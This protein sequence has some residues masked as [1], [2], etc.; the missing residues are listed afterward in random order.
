MILLKKILLCVGGFLAVAGFLARAADE[1]LKPVEWTVNDEKRQ[2][3]VILPMRKSD[4]PAP[5][6]FVFHGHG[7]T[8]QSMERKG[9]QKWWPEAIIVCPQGLPT[10]T[11]RDPEGKRSGWQPGL[12][13]NNDRD[14]KFFDAVLKTLRDKYKVDDKRIYATGHSNGGGFTYLLAAERGNILAAVAPSAAGS[15]TLAKRKDLSPLPVLHIAGEKDEIV[16]FANQQRT[17]EGVRKL[18][19]C[20]TDGK[21]WAT[22][23]KLVGT[24]YPS[25]EGPPFVS[26]IHPGTHAYPPEAPELTVKFFKEH[27]RK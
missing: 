1:P 27:S 23:G 22:S 10:A 16:P 20:E 12:G 11:I 15:G 24:I 26:V 18:N 8:M 14:L 25:K 17:M 5:V 3:L 21:P 2:A 4:D 6:I 13:K 7:G 9:F 19:G